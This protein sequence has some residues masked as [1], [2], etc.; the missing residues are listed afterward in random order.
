MK[1]SNLK[2]VLSAAVAAMMFAAGSATAVPIADTILEAYAMKNS[3]DPD[4]LLKFEALSKLDFDKGDLQYDNTP[5]VRYD[6]ASGLWILQDAPTEAGYFLLKFG[7]PK[8]TKFNTNLDTYFFRNEKDVAQLAFRAQDVNYLIGG[9]CAVGDDSKCN[10]QRLSHWRFVAGAPLVEPP[11][12]AKVPEPGSLALL[13][14][15][16]AGVLLRRRG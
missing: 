11:P 1:P 9:D 5:S 12:P 16:L 3:G 4:V 14:L 10:A 7:M 6:S 15:G 8:N 2:S 13:G